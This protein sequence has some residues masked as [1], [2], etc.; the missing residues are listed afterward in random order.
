MHLFADCC[1]PHVLYFSMTSS[2]P[3]FEA[4]VN[5]PQTGFD[6]DDTLGRRAVSE[7]H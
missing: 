3:V 2:L 6:Q 5:A 4:T 1:N 7:P